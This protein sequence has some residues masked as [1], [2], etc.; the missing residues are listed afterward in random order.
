[1]SKPGTIIVLLFV[2]VASACAETLHRPIPPGTYSAAD[3]GET[4]VITPKSIQFH[5]KLHPK[6]PD[7]FTDRGSIYEVQP[8]GNIWFMLTSNESPTYWDYSWLWQDGKIVM[9]NETNGKRTL[10]IRSDG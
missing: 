3:T 5:V 1:M 4:I 6:Q 9:I 2:L 7:L 8:D 10:F